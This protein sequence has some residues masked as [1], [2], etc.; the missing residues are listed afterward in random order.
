MVININADIHEHCMKARGNF[1]TAT[2]KTNSSMNE[3][4]TARDYNSLPKIFKC[5]I[6]Y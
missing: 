3:I 4:E 5:A 6:M 1:Y 2:R